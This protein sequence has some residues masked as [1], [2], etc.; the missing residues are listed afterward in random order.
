MRV[1]VVCKDLFFTTRIGETAKL[2][3]ASVEFARSKDELEAKLAGDPPTF[4]ILDLTTSGWD[5]ELIFGA[6][7]KHSPQIPILGFTT[8]ALAKATQPFHAR[9]DRVVTKET[10]TQEL[11]EILRNGIGMRSV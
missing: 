9:C 10:F 8:H 11:P 5:Y 2:T 3:G 1:L 7:E 6:I 4:L